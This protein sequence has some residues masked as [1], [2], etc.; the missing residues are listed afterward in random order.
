M[1]TVTKLPP[2]ASSTTASAT[3]EPTN[4]FACRTCPY[5]YALDKPYFE[6]KQFARS[7]RKQASEILSEADNMKNQERVEINCKNDKCDSREAAVVQ[8]QIRS[9]DEPMTSFFT[10]TRCGQKWR[11]N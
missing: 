3:S 1:L 6:T 4:H 2:S 7:T 10:C 5:T 9:A 11:E 8:V